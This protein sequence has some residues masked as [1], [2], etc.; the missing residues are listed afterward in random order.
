MLN[1]RN[2][3]A[4]VEGKHILNGLNL[5]VKSGEVH[6]STCASVLLPEPLGPMIA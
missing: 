5:E 6:A 4:S 1:I 2:L 3:H